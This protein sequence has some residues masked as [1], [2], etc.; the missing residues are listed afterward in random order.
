MSEQSYVNWI[1][2]ETEYYARMRERVLFPELSRA[3]RYLFYLK[4]DNGQYPAAKTAVTFSQLRDTGIGD[5]GATPTGEFTAQF[6]T[7]DLQPAFEINGI[8]QNHFLRLHRPIRIL[9]PWVSHAHH[10]FIVPSDDN[11]ANELHLIQELEPLLQ[12]QA[13]DLVSQ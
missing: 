2:K 3:A 7:M 6:Y 9:E 11:V 4:V 1:T 10:G 8:A 12:R 13:M 5:D